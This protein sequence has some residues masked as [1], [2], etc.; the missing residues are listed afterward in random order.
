LTSGLAKAFK[1]ADK[2]D[3][4]TLSLFE[5][6][7]WREAALG[8]LDAAPGTLAFDKDFDQRVTLRH[9]HLFLAD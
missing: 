8:S 5:L 3:S 6:E 4:T 2:D 1:S 7:D 9:L